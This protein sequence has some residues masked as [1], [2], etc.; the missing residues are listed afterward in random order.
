MV[1]HLGESKVLEGEMPQTLDSLVGR[2][3]ALA[4]LL[5]KFADG[6]GVQEALSRQPSPLSQRASRLALKGF[7][8]RGHRG[9]QR[10]LSKNTFV[11]LCVLCGEEKGA[12]QP[13]NRTR[14]LLGIAA[15][16]RGDFT[17]HFFRQARLIQVDQKQPPEHTSRNSSLEIGLVQ[18]VTK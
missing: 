6:I 8:H 5:E 3:L 9:S 18:R 12:L 11:I 7:H 10:N 15:H 2:K 1:I 4:D 16:F 17:K 13:R 14:Q